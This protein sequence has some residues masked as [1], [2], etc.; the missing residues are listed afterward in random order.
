MKTYALLGTNSGSV[1]EIAEARVSR[2]S[3]YWDGKW[4]TPLSLPEW[5]AIDMSTGVPIA[6]LLPGLQVYKYTLRYRIGTGSF[7]E[8]W[9]AT[10]NAVGH[11]Y[12]IKI[13]PPWRPCTRAP[14]RS[15]YWASPLCT[16][17]WYV[18]TRP[19]S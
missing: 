2:S 9:L 14:E 6:T 17:I 3:K 15:A 5:S 19:M 11:D 10:D 18:C 13:L 1:K 16:T 8:V 7:G 4:P 12:A